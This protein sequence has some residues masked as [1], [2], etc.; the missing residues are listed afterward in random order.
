MSE[1]ANEDPQ[2]FLGVVT[3]ELTHAADYPI[4]SITVAEIVEAAEL[5]ALHEILDGFPAPWFSDLGKV[6][7]E[8]YENGELTEAAEP[9]P[10]LSSEVA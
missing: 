9:V 4:E 8:M 3:W 5:R 10:I 6:A 2:T 1:Q 7:Q